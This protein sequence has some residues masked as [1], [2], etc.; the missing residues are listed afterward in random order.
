MFTL[1]PSL[2]ITMIA[3][4]VLDLCV[5]LWNSPFQDRIKGNE[6]FKNHTCEPS[7]H[8]LSLGLWLVHCSLMSLFLLCHYLSLF[9]K[10][11]DWTTTKGVHFF[12]FTSQLLDPKDSR[13][14]V[15]SNPSGCCFLWVF[16]FLGFS[17]ITASLHVCKMQ[18][19]LAP[20]AFNDLRVQLQWLH[21]ILVI[22]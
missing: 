13:C 2:Q 7:L 17:C 5:R 20:W 16:R 3:K 18:W 15:C 6:T 22:H 14:R 10:I 4:I 19:F 12:M 1:A 11:I 9:R 21:D 8:A